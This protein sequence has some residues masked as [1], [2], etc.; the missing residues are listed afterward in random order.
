[1]FN[2]MVDAIVIDWVC[3]MEATGVNAA[4]IC[5][6]TL[7]FYTDDGLETVR[8]VPISVL[9]QVGLVT[10]IIKT[11]LM[12]FLPGRISTGLSKQACLSRLNVI[13]REYRKRRQVDYHMYWKEFKAS[14]F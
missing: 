6:I 13:Y 8:A 14:S 10:N 3:L 11:E 2:I 1:M 12:E 4:N 9:E 7:V 5:I